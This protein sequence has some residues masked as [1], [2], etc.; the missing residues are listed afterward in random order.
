MSF[1]CH[2]RGNVLKTSVVSVTRNLLSKIKCLFIFQTVEPLAMP[3]FDQFRFF[4][5]CDHE[6]CGVLR[7]SDFSDKTSKIRN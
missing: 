1:S 6:S 4:F 3:R 5:C 7:L 2:S